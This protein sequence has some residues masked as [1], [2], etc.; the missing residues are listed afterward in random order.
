MNIKE[1]K[2]Y[3][4]YDNRAE[5]DVCKAHV[6]HI[7]PHPEREDDRLIVYRWYGKH[8]QRWWYG[9]TTISQQELWADYVQKVIGYR[10]QKKKCRKCGQC[11][12]YM[13]YV[14]SDGTKDHY[15]DCA[16][17]GM[18][19]ECFDGNNHFKDPDEDLLQV[20]EKEDACGFFKKNRT[21]RVKDYIRK[22]PE[23]YVQHANFF[24]KPVR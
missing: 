6:L 20:D 1:G 16:S 3:Y 8:H 9:V 14:K 18:N 17:I 2:Q 10:K 23:H 7:F 22:H 19:N 5:D 15:G 13:A 12:Y 11:G 24:P 4:F 21:K